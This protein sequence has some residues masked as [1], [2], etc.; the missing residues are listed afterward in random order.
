M[1]PPELERIITAVLRCEEVGLVPEHI[2][3]VLEAM[4]LQTQIYGQVTIEIKD[5][6]PT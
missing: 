3:E 2:A 4:I 6:K 1:T 5:E